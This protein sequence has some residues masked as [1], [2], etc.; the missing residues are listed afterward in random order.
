M[1]RKKTKRYNQQDFD[2]R[3]T[4]IM[5]NLNIFF[6][7][8]KKLSFDE[9]VRFLRTNVTIL[10]RTRFAKLIKKRANLI[11]RNVLNDLE[12]ST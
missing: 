11:R 6:Q 7:L 1:K 5:L 4:K 2:D 10:G 9:F 8:L 3:L 12:T